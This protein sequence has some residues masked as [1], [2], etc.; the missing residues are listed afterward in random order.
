MKQ[1]SDK[2]LN[3]GAEAARAFGRK[4]R[5][6]RKAAGLSQ[7]LLVHAASEGNHIPGIVTPAMGHWEVGRRIPLPGQLYVIMEALNAT[8]A[9]RLALLDLAAE[10]NLTYRDMMGMVEGL[11]DSDRLQRW[12]F[13]AA[14]SFQGLRATRSEWRQLNKEAAEE[15]AA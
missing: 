4:L 7:R 6:L 13:Q 8:E 14:S 2:P 15:D 10:A 5:E 12:E 11:P 1:G 3:K 9:N